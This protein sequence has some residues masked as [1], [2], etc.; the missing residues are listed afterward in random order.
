MVI[1]FAETKRKPRIKLTYA[2]Y[3]NAP[4]DARYV[5]VPTVGEK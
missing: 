4:D 3:L 1:E 5:T 2:D